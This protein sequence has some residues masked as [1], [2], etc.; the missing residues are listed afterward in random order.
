MTLPG[1]TKPG[2][3]AV[4]ICALS[5]Y[6]IHMATTMR[7]GLKNDRN[8]ATRGINRKQRGSRCHQGDLLHFWKLAKYA[9][10][11]PC[12]VVIW[13]D[14]FG[15]VAVDVIKRSD[16]LSDAKLGWLQSQGSFFWLARRLQPTWTPGE[17][18]ALE[19]PDTPGKWAVRY[20]WP[21]GQI[22]EGYGYPYGELPDEGTAR[23]WAEQVKRD[24]V[25]PPVASLRRC[26]PMYNELWIEVEDANGSYSAKIELRDDSLAFTGTA[27]C[28]VSKRGIGGGHYNC[29][30]VPVSGVVRWFASQR[31]ASKEALASMKAHLT[32]RRIAAAAAL[33][34]TAEYRAAWYPSLKP[35]AAAT[36]SK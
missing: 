15:V 14:V 4:G 5:C 1:S 35:A 16:D 21:N 6:H 10:K 29:K 24:L 12:D 28:G 9:R 19:W 7:W 11:E 27:H 3:F 34:K 25:N 22:R 30:I 8:H 36:A 31:V 2:N 33:Y 13:Q 20:V 18:K 23:A 32:E 26:E 17:V